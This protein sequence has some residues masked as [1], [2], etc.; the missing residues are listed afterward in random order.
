M[1]LTQVIEYLRYNAP[2][3]GRLRAR[4]DQL[5][6]RI[7]RAYVHCHGHRTDVKAQDNLIALV[8]EYIRR[9]LNETEAQA[10]A[11]RLGHKHP[12][13][14]I[15]GAARRSTDLVGAAVHHALRWRH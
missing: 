8:E 4:G 5:S 3:M 14:P 9:D 2:E 7:Y 13:D 1:T 6:D 12:D 11:N 10:L 15:V